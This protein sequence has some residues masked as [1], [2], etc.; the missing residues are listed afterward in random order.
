MKGDQAIAPST[1]R[2]NVDATRSSG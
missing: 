1:P 2:L